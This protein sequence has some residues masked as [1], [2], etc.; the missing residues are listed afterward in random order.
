MFFH[1]NVRLFEP[2]AALKCPACCASLD[3]FQGKDGPCGLFAWRQGAAAPLGQH[4]DEECA[5]P[6]GERARARLPGRFEF[7]S[8]C[9]NCGRFSTFTG[10]CSEGVWRES[11]LGSHLTNGATIPAVSVGKNWH[12]C[13]QCTEA[14]EQDDSVIRAG[15]PRC[16]ALTRLE[17][18]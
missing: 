16:N 6:L 8:S 7:Y 1:G 13:S 10:F 14:W 2:A 15:C 12:Q 11:I 3:G 5:L 17:P 18:G 9:M 4:V